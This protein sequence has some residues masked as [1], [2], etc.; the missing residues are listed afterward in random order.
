MVETVDRDPKNL[1][2]DG[3]PIAPPT[4]DNS[5]DETLDRKWVKVAFMVPDSDIAD[6]TD[7]VNR[8]YSS[9]SSKFVDSRLGC[10]IGINQKPAWTRYADIPVAGRLN[11]EIRALTVG[12]TDP[13]IGIGT[14]WS[15]NLDDPAQKI[16]LRFGVP[17]FNSLIDFLARAFNREQSIMART[18]RAPSA[19]YTLGNFVGTALAISSFPTLSVTILAGKSVAWVLARP[20]SKFFT[21]KP[22]MYMYWNMVNHLV[23][24]HAVNTGLIKKV[25]TNDAQATQQREGRPYKIDEES[26]KMLSEMMPD[27]FR[28]GTFDILAMASKAQRLANQQFDKDYEALN[29]GTA[30]DFE[31]YLKRD[32]TSDGTH[33]TYISDN[34]GEPTIAAMFNKLVKFGGSGR[35]FT[36]EKDDKVIQELDPRGQFEDTA[37][38]KNGTSIFSNLSDH[39]RSM[40]EQ[41]DA[42][43]R[44]GTAFAVFRVDHTGSVQESFGTSVQES[45]IAQKF[46]G[47]SSDMRE[48]RFSVAGGN[49]F[50]GVIN[51]VQNALTDLAIGALDGITMGFGGAIAGL[52]GSGYLDI[53]KH[54]QSSTAQLPRGSYRIRLI[55]PYNNPVSR[56]M[57]LWIPFYMLLAGIMP[58]STGQQSYTSPFYCQLFDRGRLQSRLGIMESLSITRGT[59]NLQF[60]LYG[61]CLALDLNFTIID[62]STIMHM[63]MSSGKILETDIAMDDENIAADYLNVLAG[64][65]IY[66]QIYPWPKAQLEMTKKLANMKYKATSPAFHAAF[67]KNSIQDGFINDIT[68]GLSGLVPKAIETAAAGSKTLSAG[69][70]Q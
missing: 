41:A 67:F 19:W 42:E 70:N 14:A 47:I 39:A 62:L 6:Y 63:P 27:V 36:A 4:Q 34:K 18:G 16:Y 49:I 2:I 64:M 68:L 5:D 56:L 31:G 8:Y 37:K 12:T 10:N 9:A 38:G 50:G 69:E 53:P 3:I 46:N 11:K 25:F 54:W 58:R 57:N 15:E 45:D 59:S 60:D 21:L 26:I 30:S 66:S 61:N 24:N 55:S 20:T 28:N 52:G 33:T 40:A 1:T 23:M 43:F 13:N 35:A 48:A 7:I 51:D 17:K 32:N 44:D 65:D 29:K 22:T